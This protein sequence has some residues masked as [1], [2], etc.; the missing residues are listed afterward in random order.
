M[1][2]KIN[3]LRFK[4]QLID[5]DTLK[6]TMMRLSYEVVEKNPDLSNIVLIGIKRRGIPLAKMIQE[7]IKKNT[8]FNVLMSE[9][10]IKYYRDDL[11]KVDVNPQVK[12][13]AI[14][15]EI[16]EKEII[17]VDDVLYTGRTVRAAIDAIFDYGRPSKVSLLVLVDRGHREI[18]IR[19]DYVGKNIPTSINEVIAVNVEPIDEVTNISILEKIDD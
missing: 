11:Q 7:N 5:E 1:N 17:L 14:S 4:R 16:N 18:P 8:G 3:N 13:A 2:E 10:D 12:K 6:R 15:I 9:L 19:P